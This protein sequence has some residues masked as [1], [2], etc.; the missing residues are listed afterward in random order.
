MPDD[1]SLKTLAGIEAWRHRSSFMRL[2]NYMLRYHVED[3]E[4]LFERSRPAL[5]GVQRWQTESWCQGL[6]SDSALTRNFERSSLTAYCC[7][8]LNVSHDTLG[9][10][11]T[12]IP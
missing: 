6:P 4:R 10:Q 11:F 12:N 7:P 5:L 9:C 2:T 3:V 1:L 8:A